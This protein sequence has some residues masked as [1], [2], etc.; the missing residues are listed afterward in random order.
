LV[1]AV[2]L[3]SLSSSSGGCLMHFFFTHLLYIICNKCICSIST[4]PSPL[5]PKLITFSWKLLLCHSW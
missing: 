4:Y 3:M 1:S 5:G 2:S